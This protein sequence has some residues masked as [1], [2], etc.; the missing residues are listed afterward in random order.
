MTV[1]E[2]TP[3]NGWYMQILAPYLAQNGHYIA[4]YNKGAHGSEDMLGWMKLHPNIAT[5]IMQN[6]FNPPDENHVAA[7]GSADMVLTFRN[8]HN[9]MSKHGEQAAFNGFFRAL[10]SGGILGV[11]EHRANPKGKAS[12]DTGYLKE[13]QVI[14]LAEKAGFKLVAR[15]EINANPKD[16]KDYPKGVWMLPPNNRHDPKDND[17]FS[18]I[19]ESDRMTLKF[20]KP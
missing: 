3:G 10:K 16:T 6:K 11:V 4:A 2:I 13:H 8:V 20:I 15:S 12:S 18:A 17:K 9:W 19:G 1:V 14:H 7:D 5:N